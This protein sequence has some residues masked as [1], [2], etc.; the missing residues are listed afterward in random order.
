M[1]ETR[2]WLIRHA[3]VAENELGRIYGATDVPLCPRSLAEQVPMH[4]ALARRLPAPGPDVVWL[5]SP[6]SR[7]RHTAAAIFAAGYP[8]QPLAIE[9]RLIELDFGEWHGLEHREL[10]A[11]LKLPAHEFWSIAGSERP[12]G[13]ESMEDGIAR[14][15][16]L[17]ERLAQT[18]P[19]HDVIAVTHGGVIRAAVA[20]ALRIGADNALHLSIDNLSLTRL[21]RLDRGWRV[22][23]VNELPGL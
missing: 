4:A 18:Y 15:G 21:D 8:V 20:H 22:A 19:A 14:V 16:P 1:T 9:R 11:R 6:L 12:P 17:L 5:A 7:T 2:F 13:G 10:P 23:C 3:I